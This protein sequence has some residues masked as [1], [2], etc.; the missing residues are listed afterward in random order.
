MK[1]DEFEELLDNR[2]RKIQY[3]LGKK[4]L[5]YSNEIDR[6]HNFKRAA[7]TLR[8]TNEQALIGMFSK[9]L[10]SILDLVDEESNNLLVW[11]EKLGDAINYLILLE[12]L[13]LERITNNED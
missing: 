1:L 3:T 13:V 10:V 5:E 11:D 2:I 4:A 8:C 7:E 12:A 6:L 9:H